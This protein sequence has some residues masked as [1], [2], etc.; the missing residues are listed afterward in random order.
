[1]SLVSLWQSTPDQFINKHV[2]QI[3]SF[4]GDGK[5]KDGNSTSNEFRSFI[6]L[7]PSSVLSR[8]AFD[9]LESK[10]E[11][12]GLA[13]Q[14]IVNQAGRRLGFQVHDGRYKG[15][16][17]QIGYDGLWEYSDGDQ[18]IIEVKTTDAY[19]IDLN[20][21]AE[22][23][24]SLI[25]KNDV[26]EDRSSI[27]IV[28]GRQD[29]GDLE[30]QVRGSRHAWNVRLLSI[31]SLFRLISINEEIEGPEVARKICD[32][33]IPREYTRVDGIID[34]VFETTAEV[35]DEVPDE[36]VSGEQLSISKPEVKKPKFKPVGFHDECLPPIQKKLNIPFI[37]RSK[38]TYISAD[39]E[40]A[41]IC[42]VSREHHTSIGTGYWFAFYTHQQDKLNTF[43]KAY[44]A[45]GCGSP[46]SV[47]L[48]PF[49]DF[50]QWFDGMNMTKTETR[51]YW[52]VQ[53]IIDGDRYLLIQKA[54]IE[55]VD[56]TKYKI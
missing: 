9:C 49:K 33:L 27:L 47:L 51:E 29:T 50:Q 34:L 23:R 56:L 41:L 31:E 28:V 35:K 17:G 26:S 11:G 13:L 32:L 48:I 55:R 8:Y 46:D 36:E 21:I 16:K 52:H 3:I 25:K 54:N 4:A 14:D 24:R 45:F 6:D 39:K 22:Y 38:A 19:R 7:V 20:V 44:V 40:I 37:R 10:F 5:L 43:K 2:Q 15:I 18:L 1:M 12:S 53:I 30:A 42:K